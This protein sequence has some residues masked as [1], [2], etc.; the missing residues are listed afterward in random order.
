MPTTTPTIR[1]DHPIAVARGLIA[2]ALD[3]GAGM[4]DEAALTL[5]EAWDVLEEPGRL[6]ELIEPVVGTA[7][8]PTTLLRRARTTLRNSIPAAG[9]AEGAL[10]LAAAI[11]H[12]D[13]ALARLDGSVKDAWGGHL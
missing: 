10:R 13:A 3:L 1:P 5:S 9:S 2:A 11:R 7:A 8:T 4:P 12:L 6:P